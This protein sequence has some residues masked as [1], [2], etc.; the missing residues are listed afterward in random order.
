MS[1]QGWLEGQAIQDISAT[2]LGGYV[3]GGACGL[4]AGQDERLLVY[5]PEVVTLA[6][7]L[8]QAERPQLRVPVWILGARMLFV[9]LDGTCRF[10]SRMDHNSNVPIL[11]DLVNVELSGETFNIS[12]SRPYLAFMS[13]TQGFLHDGGD[14]VDIGL[15]RRNKHPRQRNVDPAGSDGWFAFENQVR[16]WFTGVAL[17]SYAAAVR[18]AL[19]HLVRSVGTGPWMA[20][21]W[22]GDSQLGFLAAWIGQAIAART[23]G[24][25][26]PLDYYLYA[27]FTENPGNQCFVGSREQC[28]ACLAHCVASPLPSSAYWLPKV[29]VLPGQGS[30]CAGYPSDCGD[31]GLVDVAGSYAH[32]SAAELWNDVESTLRGSRGNTAKSVFDLLTMPSN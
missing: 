3:F 25:A 29:A 27:T 26:L 30:S 21:L 17:S 16:A 1:G 12:S 20:G 2:F 11:R 28:R 6:F 5:M 31:R 24:R 4:A 10:D 14:G 13:D 22:W 8:S 19:R 23:W 15:A 7:F 32:R 18:P 9:G